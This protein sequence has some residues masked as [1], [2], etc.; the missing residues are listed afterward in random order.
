MKKLLFILLILS[1]FAFGETQGE[2]ILREIDEY[3]SLESDGT[4]KVTITTQKKGQG[5]KQQEMIYYR[6]DSTDSFLIIMVAPENEK[7]NGYLKQGENMWVYRKNTRTFQHINSDESIGGSG[8]TA[9]DFE[10]KKLSEEYN[11]AM[12]DGKEKVEEVVLGGMEVYK[13]ELVAKTDAVKDPKRI[14]WV[15]KENYL[16]LR[17]QNFSLSGT[18]MDTITF[19]KYKK[20]D[21]SYIPTSQLIVDEFDLG[22]KSLVNLTDISTEEIPSHIFTKAYLENLSK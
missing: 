7:G 13:I 17:I 5:I 11:I 19:K 14:Y 8:A 4:A 12:E 18:L 2:M 16:P 10:M 15:A 22:N 1:Q 3:L 6:Q 9:D 21:G 20:I